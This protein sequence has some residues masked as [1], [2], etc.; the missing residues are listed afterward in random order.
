MRSFLGSLTFALFQAVFTFFFVPLAL[1][2]FWMNPIKRYR[3]MLWWPRLNL[4][5]AR[6]LCGI[7]HRVIGLEN[8][9]GGALPHIVLSKHSSTWEVLAIPLLMPR[10]LCFV[11]KKELLRI[12]FFGWGFSLVKP[13]TIDRSSGSHAMQQIYTQ[14]EVRLKEGFWMILFPEGTRVTPGTKQRYKTGGARLAAMLD[15]PVLPIAHNAGHLWP[16]GIFGKRAGT[17]TIS[18][19]APILSKGKEPQQIMDE[20]QQWIESEVTRM[21]SPKK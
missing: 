13:I 3:F 4:W 16:R 18:I 20:V 9:P 8:I 19:G 10:P 1:C 12:P 2:L 17:I 14:G 11:A 7:R 21:G 5:A 6:L 15:V